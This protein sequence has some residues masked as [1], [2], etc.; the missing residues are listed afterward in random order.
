MKKN[1]SKSDWSIGE[2]K[3]LGRKVKQLMGRGLQ[4]S[5]VLGA[6]EK[7]QDK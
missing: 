5:D 7:S 4:T 3:T 6:E 2:K 1:P